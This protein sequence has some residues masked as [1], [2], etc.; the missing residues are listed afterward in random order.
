MR[1]AMV[2]E[3][4]EPKR[5]GAETYVVDLCR[6]LLADGHEVDLIA[7]R[8][9]PVAL[10]DGLTIHPVKVGGWTR[11]AALWNFARRSRIALDQ[12]PHDVSIGFINTWGT[13]I[14]IPQGGIR[15]ASLRHNAARFAHPLRRAIY[16]LAKS[17]NPSAP[18][19]RTIERRQYRGLGMPDDPRRIVAV[20]HFVKGH[21]QEIYQVPEQVIRVIPNAI[22]SDRVRPGDPATSRRRL[23]V[24]QGIGADETVAL[25]VAHNFALKG[26]EPLLEAVAFQACSGSRPLTLLVCGGGRVETYRR[27]AERLGIDDRVRFLGYYPQIADCYAAADL[28]VL[29]SYYDPCSL[30]VFE[31]LACG[32]PVITTACNGAGELIEPGREGFVIP[33]P[34]EVDLLADALDVLTEPGRRARMVQ[35]ARRLA[36]SCRFENHYRLLM[37]VIDEVVSTRTPASTRLPAPRPHWTRTGRAMYAGEAQRS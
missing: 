21:L 7:H 25:F 14:L 31:A 15:P 29:P 4:I 30:V 33:S 24:E 28:F 35:E 22:D 16:R 34:D 10:P 27:R 36:E 12:T 13:D 11:Q 18:L 8:W 9:D 23:R 17:L 6:R 2:Y 20:S 37:N 26:L 19:Y 1:I 5:G 3:R 32:L